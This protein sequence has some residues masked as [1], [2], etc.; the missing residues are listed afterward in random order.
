MIPIDVPGFFLQYKSDPDNPPILLLFPEPCL[1][2]YK[3]W[4]KEKQEEERAESIVVRRKEERG[5]EA[6]ENKPNA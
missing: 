4:A 6:E 5:L 2:D 1:F 3:G